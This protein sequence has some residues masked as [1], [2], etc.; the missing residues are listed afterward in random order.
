MSVWEQ[1]K[2]RVKNSYN[3]NQEDDEERRRQEETSRVDQTRSIWEQ[4]KQSIEDNAVDKFKDSRVAEGAFYQ[5]RDVDAI[6]RTAETR[7]DGFKMYQDAVNSLNQPSPAQPQDRLA[8]LEKIKAGDV[9]RGGSK[10]TQDYFNSLSKEA[11]DA[12]LEWQQAQSEGNLDAASIAEG[13]LRAAVNGDEQAYIDALGAARNINKR[14]N[15]VKKGKSFLN[16]QETLE[17]SQLKMDSLNADE[18][19]VFEKI[20]AGQAQNFEAK[21]SI[22]ENW[23]ANPLDPRKAFATGKVIANGIQGTQQIKEGKKELKALGWSDDKIKEYL[24][25]SSRLTNKAETDKANERFVIDPNASTGQKIW[26]SI[27]NSAYDLEQV[28]PRGLMSAVSNVDRGSLGRDVYS[29]F[30]YASNSTEEAQKQVVNNAITD[31]HP[32]GQRAYQIGMS[33][34][35]SAELAAIGSAVG[36]AA[37]SSALAK[38]ATKAAA[39]S[40]AKTAANIA[41]LPMFGL[42]AYDSGYKDAKSRGLSEEQAQMFGLASGVAEA[43]TEVFSLDHFWDMAKNT[44]VGKNL[45]MDWLAQAGIEGSEEVASNILNRFSDWAIAGKDGK[46]QVSIDAREIMDANPGMSEEE[47]RGLAYKNWWKDTATAFVDGAISGGLFGGAGFVS[48]VRNAR[49]VGKNLEAVRAENAEKVR[50]GDQSAQAYV[51][52]P[53][54]LYEDYARDITEEE[55]ARKAEIKELADEYDKKGKLSLS[56]RANA[57]QSIAVAA[58]EKAMDDFAQQVTKGDIPEEFRSE[59]TNVTADDVRSKMQSAANDGNLEA[60]MDAYNEGRNAMSAAAREEAESL[61]NEATI[62]GQMESKGISEDQFN[63]AKV[64][65]EEAYRMGVSGEKAE[66]LSTRAQLAYNEGAKQAVANRTESFNKKADTIDN[67]VAR[68][69]YQENLKEG[70]NIHQYNRAWDRF[71]T[72]GSTGVSFEDALNNKDNGFIREVFDDNTLRNIH[73]AGVEYT[74]TVEGKKAKENL[75]KM[76]GVKAGSGSFSD[77]RGKKARKADNTDYSVFKAL[78]SYTNLDIVIGDNASFDFGKSENARF[79]PGESKVVINA[80]ASVAQGF[81]EVLGEWTEFY[82]G[83]DYKAVRSSLVK[84]ASDVLGAKAYTNIINQYKQAY[85]KAGV[86]NADIEMSGEFAN[87]LMVAMMSTEKGRNALANTLAANTDVQKATDII[88]RIKELFTKLVDSIKSILD[89][90]NLAPQQRLMLEKGY[91]ELESNVDA[92]MDALSKARENALNAQKAQTETEVNAVT[93]N[94]GVAYDVESESAYPS[95]FSLNTWNASDYVT[96][97]KEAA[98]ALSKTLGVSE[99]KALKWIDDI[100]SIAKIIADDRARLDFDADENNS[101]VVSNAEY[102][103]SIDFSTICKKRLLYTGTLQAIQKQIGNRVITMEDYLDIRKAMLEDGLETTCGC[104]YVEGSRVKLGQFMKEFIKRYSKDNP[105]YIPTM[106]DVTMPDGIRQLRAQHPEVFAAREKFLNNRGVL[107]EGESNLFSSQGKPK[108]YTERTEYRGELLNMFEGKPEK[109]KDKNRNGGL[110]IQ[111]FSDFEIVNLLDCMQVITDMAR[112][113]L[114]GQAYTKVYDFADALGNTGLKINLSLMGAGVDANGDLILDEVN[115]MKKA[116]AIKLRNKYSKN[117][118]TIIVC[119]TD[120]QIKAAMKSDYIDFII[121]FHRSQWRKSQYD[122]LGLPENTRDYTMH[123]NDRV[124]KENGR[125]KKAETNHMPNEYWDFTKTGRENAEKYIQM[126]NDEGKAPKF[127]FLLGKYDNG[128]YYLP[129]GKEYDGYFKLLIDFKMYDNDGVGSPQMPVQPNF[130]MEE[131]ARMLNEYTGGHDSFPVNKKIADEFSEKIK[132]RG[133]EFNATASKLHDPKLVDAY[134][135]S[136][137]NN[138]G[139]FKRYQLAKSISE[140]A[141]NWIQ[142]NLGFNVSD[143]TL[144]IN[145][146]AFI[147]IDKRH[148]EN[149]IHDHSMADP[150]DIAMA[151]YVVNNADSIDYVYDNGGEIELSAEFRDINNRPSKQLMFRKRIG[152]SYYVVVAVG[153]N[154]KKKLWVISEYKNKDTSQETHGNKSLSPTSETNLDTVSSDKII[155]EDETKGNRYSLQVD[156]DGN[157]LTE[158]QKLKFNG[159]AAVDE[160]GR[161][162]KVYHGTVREFYEFDRSYSNV[163]GNI[164]KG[165][166][167]TN[168]AVDVDKNYANRDG[169]DFTS[170]VE[171]EADLLEGDDEF[172]DEHPDMDHDDIVEYLK[173]KYATAEEPITMECYLDIKNPVYIGNYNGNRDTIL[174]EDLTSEI[175]EE[176]FEDEDDYYQALDEA[177]EETIEDVIDHVVNNIEFFEGEEDVNKLRSV[178]YE[179]ASEGGATFEQLRNSLGDQFIYDENYDMADSE[180]VRLVAEALGYDGVIDNTVSQK[181]PGMRLDK[182]TTHFIVFNSNQAKLTTNENPTSSADVRYSIGVDAEAEGGWIDFDDIMSEDDFLNSLGQEQTSILEKGMEALK[183]KSVDTQKLRGMAIRLRNEVGSS[184]EVKKFEDMLTKAFAY[185]QTQQH[186][187]YEDMMSILRDIAKPVVEAATTLEGEQEYKDFVSEFKPYTIKLN[188]EQKQEVIS[189][190]GSYGQFKNAMMPIKISENGTSLDSLWSEISDINP[191]LIPADTNP[192]DQALVLHDALAAMRPTP[193]NDYGGNINEV[194]G[195]LAMRIVEEYVGGEQGKKMAEANKKYKAELRKRYNERLKEARK[196]TVDETKARLEARNRKAAERA[197]ESAAIKEEKGKIQTKAN[198]LLKW[199]ANPTEQ[200]HV[201]SNMVMPIL[202]FL[203]SFDFVSPIIT[204]TNNGWS[205]KVLISVDSTGKR[206]YETITGATYKETLNKYKERLGLGEGSQN[207]RKWYERMESIRSIYEQA[208][209][210][211]FDDES[212]SVVLGN[213]DA[214]LYEQYKNILAMYRGKADIN[215]MGSA[216]LKVFKNMLSNIMAA[217]NKGNKANSINADIADMGREIIKNADGKELKNRFSAVEGFHKFFRLDNVNPRTFMTLLGESGKKLYKALRDGMNTRT[218]DIKKASDYMEQVKSDLGLTE[219]DLQ[220]LTGAKATIHEFNV[221][222]GT[223]RMTTAQIMGLYETMKRTG[224]KDRIVGGI[225]VGNIERGR[226]EKNI[227]Q[228]RTYHLSE[229]DL[230][231]IFSVLSDKQKALADKMQWY[232]ANECSKQG[233]EVSNKLYGYEKF[234]DPRYY[235]WTVD[236]NTIDTRDS[237]DKAE[238]FT[239]IERSGFTNALKEGANNPLVIKDIFDVFTSHVEDMA[240][241]HGYAAANKD[242]LRWL[243][244]KEKSTSDNGYDVNWVTVKNAINVM[245]GSRSGVD[246]IKKL[247]RNLN[248]MEKSSYIGGVTEALMGNYKASAVGANLRVIFQQPTAYL[249]AL[250]VIEPKYLLIVSPAKG[251]KYSKVAIEQNAT[252]MWKSWGYYETNIGKS[253]KE[254]IVG[255]TDTVAKVQDILMAAAGKA[256]DIT[257]GFLYAAVENE[258]RDLLKG[259]GLSEEEFRKAVNDRFD[260]VVDRTQVVDSTLHRSQ[261]MRGTDALNKLQTAFMAEPTKSYNM[262]L[263]AAIEDYREGK[264]AK[265]TTRAAV[266]F[267]LSAAATAAAAAVQDANKQDDDDTKWTDVW[268]E[269]FIANFKDNANPL[270]LVPVVKD[271]VPTLWG[272]INGENSF[273]SSNSRFDMEAFTS[274]ANAIQAWKKFGEGESNKS[275]YGMLMATIKPI[276]QM[277]GIPLYNLTRDVVS[278]TNRFATDL[279]TTVT[280]PTQIKQGV[281]KAVDRGDSIEKIQSEVTEGLEK[282]IT[283]KEMQSYLE[284]QYKDKYFDLMQEGNIEEAEKYAEVVSAGFAA[285]LMSDEDIDKKINSWAEE[286]ITYSELDKAIASGEGIAEAMERVKTAKDDDKIVKHIMDRFQSTVDYENEMGTDTDYKVRVEEALKLVDGSN[287]YDSVSEDLERKAQEKAEKMEQNAEKNALKQKLFDAID[288]RNGSAGRQTIQEMLNKGIEAKTIKSSISDEYHKAWLDASP[289]ERNAIKQK[290]IDA[291]I[292]VNNVGNVKNAKDPEKTWN[293]WEAKQK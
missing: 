287:T 157:E 52:N 253:M 149:G 252:A 168:N 145:T 72:A 148:G 227:S 150:K 217:V 61:I 141:Q 193:V 3:Q 177:L 48:S 249:R 190:F 93:Q 201:P 279:R 57:A 24:E 185:M 230:K 204:K 173:D 78:A 195:D 83:E 232:L 42:S 73:E 99:K 171:R 16:D 112:C 88:G 170:K 160:E 105:S 101:A 104:C 75:N 219:K 244:Y 186:V 60:L 74:Q 191:T 288:S 6:H 110:R 10:T 23:E 235:P 155:S 226:L 257:W 206:T 207:A 242:V 181:F 84:A 35:E 167:F 154:T 45:L 132:A 46:D 47:A 267:L 107:H 129:Q 36:G 241:Y 115:G 280:T 273:G 255:Q 41:T 127:P 224:A 153:E 21:S 146:N 43:A 40:A 82:N 203:Q 231:N 270:N 210:G 109:V 8:E 276:S 89:N 67:D 27:K 161:L 77:I 15:D 5:Q 225:K 256:D 120:E 70:D 12:A 200:N 251:L 86:D 291:T 158:G 260:E 143:Y 20:A 34:A 229:G 197:K 266:A 265:R 113:G 126:C 272:A 79:V 277:T 49:A 164:G 26:Q 96:N 13:K 187:N 282:G 54:R 215:Q 33:V 182:D 156:T 212:M 69:A 284:S 62:K 119:F 245:T 180:I 25:Y 248:K 271:V 51:N 122:A 246:Y 162:V 286:S 133:K 218:W 202:D 234:L 269:N 214:S 39:E 14:N 38:G 194:A 293:E 131:C 166:Y 9:V 290:W 123:Q 66:G 124:I 240:S 184:Y 134:L 176:D 274:L 144:D 178:L 44:K 278:L 98:K 221:T 81:H 106:Y 103:A 283:I 95:D 102:G 1:Y 63:A 30:N 50:Q 189:A 71:F 18:K 163:E 261:L 151:E 188:A 198:K 237:N 108:D 55:Q 130:S 11:Q 165:F 268:L 238:S 117:V 179:V 37:A 263:E 140:Y 65:T 254:V 135:E 4:Y 259:K 147:H 137:K 53:L 183:G 243:N 139:V 92:L 233:N 56:D 281:K 174:L 114:A 142:K 136:K 121:P 32:I 87:D 90:S 7:D 169:A 28:V 64:S 175:Y 211:Q 19:K 111:S 275:A 100:N 125:L 118:G 199:I 236:K 208:S 250:D 116:D 91:K 31:A 58:H 138:H 213:L 247:L 264:T 159:T 196:K 222:G 262:L 289:S 68:A 2:N 223:M 292:L 59:R 76:L 22:T 258:Q 17:Y 209:N 205:T 216:D 85:G 220:T 228:D 94:I 239:G 80:D 97:R 192:N 128:N 29:G 152:D 285:T 172:M